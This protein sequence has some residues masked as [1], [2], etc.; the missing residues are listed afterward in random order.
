MDEAGHDA[1]F[2]LVWLDDAWTVGSDHSGP[3]LTS[4]SV[5]HVNHVQLRN[6]VRDHN[7]QSDLRLNSLHDRV[8]SERG[9]H[10]N[11]TCVYLSQLIHSLR[12][13]FEHRQSQMHAPRLLR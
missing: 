6:S 1:Y 9:W 3:V 5:L 10:I 7:H 13:V 2:A 4:Q 11:H 12:T 8:P